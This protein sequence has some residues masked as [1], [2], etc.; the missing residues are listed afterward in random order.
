MQGGQQGPEVSQAQS[1]RAPKRWPLVN[2][3][4]SRNNSPKIDARLVNAYAEKNQNTGQYEVEKRGGFASIPELVV[5]GNVG[6]GVFNYSYAHFGYFGDPNIGRLYSQ[7]IFVN[8]GIA[9]SYI[10]DADGVPSGP[11]VLGAVTGWQ[12]GSK[13][14]FLGMPGARSILLFSSNRQGYPAACSVY[15]VVTGTTILEQLVPGD[16]NNFPFDIVAGLVYLDGYVYVMAIDGNIYQTSVPNVISGPG[17][18]SS[19]YIVAASEPDLGVQIAK[20]GIYIVAIKTWTTQFFYDAG[21]PPPGSSLSPVPGALF[22]VG[23]M[24]ADTFAELDGV[25]FWVTNSRAGT[26]QIIMVA[27]LHMEVISSPAVERLLDL[28]PGSTWYSLAYQHCGHHFYVIT[29]VTKNTTLVYDLGEKLWYVWTD[30]AGN[31]YPVVARTASAA[32]DEW[33]QLGSS[34]YPS[35]IAGQIFDMDG[36]YTNTNDWG[37]LVPVDIYTP[38]FDAGVD[39][40]KLLSQMRINADQTTGSS[41]LVRCNDEDYN[42]TKWTNFRKVDLGQKRPYLNDEGSFYRRAYHFRHYANTPFRIRSVDLQMDLGTL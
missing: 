39:R 1:M 37:N 22:N 42:P 26:Y 40:A 28:G 2:T 9:Y 38:N 10:I 5:P 11:T 17:A 8:S 27:N 29:N 14:Q 20:Q 33:H 24:D 41:V 3:F 31:F 35:G 36:D 15:Y 25:L 7:A 34:P 23:C 4:D 19:G 30:F 13:F 12:A 18:W 32:G 16:A 21:N 6:Q